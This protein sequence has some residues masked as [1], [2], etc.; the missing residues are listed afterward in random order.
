[1]WLAKYEAHV[2]LYHLTRL[3]KYAAKL[4]MRAPMGALV[5]LV[6]LWSWVFDR[7]AARAPPRRRGE[8]RPDR[9]PQ[10]RQGPRVEG[11]RPRHG[12]AGRRGRARRARARLARLARSWGVPDDARPATSSPGGRSGRWAPCWSGLLGKAGTPADK[13][14]TDV[15]T[16]DAAGPAAADGRGGDAG[17]AVARHLGDERQGSRDHLPGADQPRRHRLAR[18]R[19]TPARRHRRRRGREARG[20]GRRAAPPAG[21][22]VAGAT[23]RS[24]PAGWCCSSPTRTCRSPSRTLA[25]AEVRHGGPVRSRS[26]S[27]P[28]RAAGWSR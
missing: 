27:A 21:L 12:R 10:A 15:A 4:A 26:R 7:E 16:V 18:R 2:T 5:L 17:A 23:P 25:A 6:A 1:M 24:T 8:D 11:P 3:P 14:V 22:C 28:T 13:R 20:A 19:R 9:L